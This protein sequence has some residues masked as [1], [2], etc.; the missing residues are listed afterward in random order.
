VQ[1]EIKNPGTVLVV[2][3]AS[4][5]RVT[6]ERVLTRA[7]YNVST[8]DCGED[9]LLKMGKNPSEVV[10]LD[11]K[12]PGISGVEVL[13]KI[14]QDWPAT[15][16]VI[17]TAYA[18]QDIAE[19]SLALGAG[20]ILIKPV[21]DINLI[22]ESITKA[23]IR[24]KIKREGNQLNDRTFE[25]LLVSQGLV[26]QDDMEKAKNYSAQHKIRL[27]ESV[28]SLKLVS[29]EEIDWNIAQFL[30]IPYLRVYEK[31]LDPEL[32]KEF[33]PA[34]AH[35]YLC[36]PLWKEDGV[37]HLVMSDP[38]NAAAI[39]E[40]EKELRMKIKPAKG[41]EYELAALVNKLYG[42]KP[43]APAWKELIAKLKSTNPT[44]MRKALASILEHA[45]IEQ[46]ME[47]SISPAEHGLYEFRLT[48]LLKQPK[49]VEGK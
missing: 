17:M 43:K 9:A 19:E 25:Q 35:K 37:M 12:M 14:K 36:L 2:D 26:S 42:P 11:I 1:E 15:E 31:M 40:I 18:D 10:L 13:R 28:I 7:G 45:K 33:P 24:S 16:V 49:K 30:E 5:M 20:E 44:E 6:S 22:A 47:A 29:E 8:A 21:D 38:F 34:L 4:I 48:A 3:D 27:R 41:V 32:I 39:N 46:I 23:M